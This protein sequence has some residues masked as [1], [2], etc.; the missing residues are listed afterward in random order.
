MRFPVVNFNKGSQKY[1]YPL[2]LALSNHDFK[3]ALRLL[4]PKHVVN[5]NARDMECN[6]AFHFLMGHFG[7]D[8]ELAPKIAGSLLKKEIE[9]NLLNKSGLTPLHVA[10][11]N[12]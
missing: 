8:C 12:F 2:H 7:F 3:L 1:G 4:Q 9:M 5:V 11:K 6:N 10:V